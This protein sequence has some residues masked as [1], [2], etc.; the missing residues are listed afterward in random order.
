M[1][2]GT[3]FLGKGK[4]SGAGEASPYVFWN[5]SHRFEFEFLLIFS[6]ERF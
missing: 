3:H 1:T 4:I 2:D 6:E 5:F